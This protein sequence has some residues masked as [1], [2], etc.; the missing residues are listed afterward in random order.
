L[1]HDI[2]LITGELKRGFAPLTKPIPLPLDKG[3]GIKGIGSP[4]KNLRG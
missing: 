1:I 3:K 2:V 4:S